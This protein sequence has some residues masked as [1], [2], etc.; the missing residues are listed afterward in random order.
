M[1]I[2]SDP[3]TTYKGYA[4]LSRFMYRSDSQAIFRRFGELHVRNLLLLQQELQLLEDKLHEC[5]KLP[6]GHE[7]H[8]TV[9]RDGNFLRRAL[10]KQ[11]R[12]KIQE[13]GKQVGI[14]TPLQ[15]DSNH[16]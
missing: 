7:D 8:G 4:A 10:V 3:T 1:A 5:D 14:Y 16:I 15:R 12:A 2:E 9:R 11:L 13:Y 6:G